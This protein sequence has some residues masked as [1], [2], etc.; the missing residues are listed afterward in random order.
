M[1]NSFQ[2]YPHHSVFSFLNTHLSLKLHS[3]KTILGISVPT[4]LQFLKD[5]L[6]QFWS[7]YLVLL[8]KYLYYYLSS[9]LQ[10]YFLFLHQISSIILILK[11]NYLHHHY[12]SNCFLQIADSFHFRQIHLNF[13]YLID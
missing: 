11:F 4:Y 9:C 6:H 3:K 5:H 10:M 13:F 1:K 7:K 12:Q 2:H 8:A